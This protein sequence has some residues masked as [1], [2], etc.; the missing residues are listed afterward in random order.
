M[1]IAI[2]LF[3]TVTA[4]V[5]TTGTS[6]YTAP[7][8]Y[9]TVVLLAQVSNIGSTL[10]TVSANHVR[11]G[12][13]T[14]IITNA[15]LPVSDAI[16]LLSGKLILQTGDSISVSASANDSSCRLVAV[17][18][19]HRRCL[20]VL[21]YVLRGEHPT[22]TRLRVNAH[23]STASA[24]VFSGEDEHHVWRLRLDRRRNRVQH[25]FEIRT[26]DPQGSG[27]YDEPRDDFGD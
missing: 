25:N 20:I 19:C 15:V 26:V 22:I 14:N 2:N 4:N 18:P 17:R 7:A 11:S 23:H 6:V 5:T 3:K 16:S 27:Y 13:A 12:A 10:L 24:V 1:A 21:D 8:G 9:T